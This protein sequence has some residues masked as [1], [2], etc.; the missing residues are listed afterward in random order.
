MNTFNLGN[1]ADQ[2][3]SLYVRAITKRNSKEAETL[4]LLKTTYTGKQA[5][6]LSATALHVSL[7]PR[8]LQ[9]M[10]QQGVSGWIL[11]LLNGEDTPCPIDKQTGLYGH[12]SIQILIKNSA[13]IAADCA[14]QLA[15]KKAIAAAK[16][17]AA[18]NVTPVNNAPMQGDAPKAELVALTADVLFADW[19][20]LSQED[21]ESFT[22]LVQAHRKA[23]KPAFKVAI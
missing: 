10:T 12:A 14:K 16:K 17:A 9:S 8:M 3:I 6:H 4:K 7:S 19:L 22:K 2:S 11:K 20:T 21:K 15:D 23:N 13:T 5:E 1:T 18:D